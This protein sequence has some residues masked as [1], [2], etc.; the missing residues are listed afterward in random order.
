[1][2]DLHNLY[3]LAS[4]GIMRNIYL[5]LCKLRSHCGVEF[6]QDVLVQKDGRQFVDFTKFHDTVQIDE[7]RKAGTILHVQLLHACQTCL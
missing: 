5:K 6:A 3:L 7:Q 2:R 4:A 1:M